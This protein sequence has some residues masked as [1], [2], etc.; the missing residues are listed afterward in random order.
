MLCSNLTAS[1]H[2]T[3]PQWR[4][5]QHQGILRTRCQKAWDHCRRP[6]RGY[7]MS[8][9]MQQ[10]C[11]EQL[12]NRHDQGSVRL[13]QYRRKWACLLPTACPVCHFNSNNYRRDECHMSVVRLSSN[14]VHRWLRLQD[15]H[16]HHSKR[17]SLRNSHSSSLPRRLLRANL[18]SRLSM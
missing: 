10:A 12:I 4:P 7:N 2:H 6:H 8:R 16:L 13:A 15:L 1:R 11:K 5:Q 9:P 18:K 14:Q 17:R 3:L